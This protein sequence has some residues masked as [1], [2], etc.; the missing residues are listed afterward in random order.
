MCACAPCA[1]PPPTIPA[2]PAP[3]ARKQSFD[4]NDGS[5][6]EWWEQSERAYLVG[7]QL[8]NQRSKYGY[9]VLESLEELGRLAET[10]G[11]EVRAAPASA[12]S[13]RLVLGDS[14][15][16]YNWAG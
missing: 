9:S 15:W 8:K 13:D 1:P 5:D 10:A 4:L 3:P 12:G 7:V 11:L 16:L 6:L 14:A 2:R